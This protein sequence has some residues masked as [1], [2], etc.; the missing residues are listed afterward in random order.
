MYT[1][2][3]G[4]IKGHVGGMNQA[5]N[6]GMLLMALAR[7][8][9]DVYLVQ[10]M[11]GPDPVGLRVISS[12]LRSARSSNEPADQIIEVLVEVPNNEPSTR[13][14]YRARSRCGSSRRRYE[15]T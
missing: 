2:L 5:E 8:L 7:R 13:T 3:S 14:N 1:G 10:R 15:R 11:V 12:N 9:N 6:V 4:R